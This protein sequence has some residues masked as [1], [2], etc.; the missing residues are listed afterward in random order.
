MTSSDSNEFRSAEIRNADLEAEQAGFLE[1]G[2]GVDVS[3]SIPDYTLLNR[4]GE[5]GSSV[6]YR[7]HRAGKPSELVAI[8]ILTRNSFTDDNKRLEREISSLKSFD[9]RNICRLYDYGTTENGYPFLVLQYVNGV[10]IDQ[11]ATDA[12]PSFEQRAI[13]IAK[14]CRALHKVHELGILHRDLQPGNIVVDESGE[15]ILMDFGL[16]KS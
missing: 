11:Y 2:D 8:K 3:I 12:R 4:I 10:N 14:V 15:P 9:H 6:V 13:L 7:A 1:I 5:G 16:S